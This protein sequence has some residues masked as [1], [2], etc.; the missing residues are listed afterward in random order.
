MNKGL[1]SRIHEEY[2]IYY[3]NQQEKDTTQSMD[4]SR[5]FKYLDC[6]QFWVASALQPVGLARDGL[7]EAA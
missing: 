5:R 4:F 7:Q 6:F 3:I 1:V 2:V